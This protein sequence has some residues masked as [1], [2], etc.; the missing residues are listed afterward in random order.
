MFDAL[1]VFSN[2]LYR[3]TS[4]RN[5]ISLLLL[6]AGYFW[7]FNFSTLPFSNPALISAGCG[8]GMLDARFYYTA[9]EAHQ[10]LNCYGP[11]GR[12]IYRHF[13]MADMTFVFIYGA[14][15]ALLL[16][17]LLGSLTNSRWRLLSL[18]PVGIALAD[19]TENLLIFR[20]LAVY[21]DFPAL[22]GQIAGYA[23]LI[24]SILSAV[25][26]IVLLTCLVTLQRQRIR[27]RH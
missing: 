2:A 15:F 17:R 10:A 11:T 3:H 5:I 13:L 8:E 4:W 22:L 7:V 16:S 27:R 20:L 6:F 25:A 23:T 19:A 21:P 1:T 9:S 14:G 18:L 24:K 12:A 26:V